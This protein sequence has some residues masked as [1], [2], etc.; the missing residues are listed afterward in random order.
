MKLLATFPRLETAAFVAVA[1]IG[2]KLALEFPM[3]VLGRTRA[4]PPGASYATAQEYRA[5]V[6]AH[7]PSFLRVDHS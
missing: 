7:A 6:D 4:F 3:D 1:V 2:G 5:L